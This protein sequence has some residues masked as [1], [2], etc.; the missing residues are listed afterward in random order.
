MQGALSRPPN[1][2]ETATILVGSSIEGNQA[3]EVAGQVL[4]ILVVLLCPAP[5]RVLWWDKAHMGPFFQGPVL[6][7][8]IRAPSSDIVRLPSSCFALPVIHNVLIQRPEV[9]VGG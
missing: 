4:Y 3:T 9:A 7:P 6:V 5:A 1:P 2:A 8:S